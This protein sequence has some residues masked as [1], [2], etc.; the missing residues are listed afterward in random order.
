VTP[1]P[2]NPVVGFLFFFCVGGVFG[3]VLVFLFVFLF[4]GFLVVWGVGVVVG[5]FGGGVFVFL[6]YVLL[7]VFL[8]GLVWWCW[9]QN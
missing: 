5:L 3:V 2:P 9:L 8:F 7:V 1:S 6:Y 4:S